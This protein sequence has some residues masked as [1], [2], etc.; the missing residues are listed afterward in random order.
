MIRI[1][2]D[3]VD[4]NENNVKVR[5]TMEMNSKGAAAVEEFKTL[6]SEFPTIRNTLLKK[7]PLYVQAEILTDM[8]EEFTERDKDE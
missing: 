2:V 1:T 3:T 7:F 4:T 8:L 6:N 5:V